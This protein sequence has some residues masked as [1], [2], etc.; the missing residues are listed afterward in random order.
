M[1]PLA[2]TMIF[3]ACLSGASGYIAYLIQSQAERQVSSSCS[4][5]DPITV[6][7][8]ALGI[9][10]FLIAEGLVAIFIHKQASILKQLTRCIRICIG[11]SIIVIHIMQFIHK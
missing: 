6:D 10:V 4:Y 3:T 1:K 7:I 2:K 9:G 5:L 8:F 11:T